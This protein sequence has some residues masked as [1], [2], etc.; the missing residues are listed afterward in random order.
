MKEKLPINAARDLMFAL[1][2]SAYKTNVEEIQADNC[3]DL[4]VNIMELH[5]EPGVRD[6]MIAQIKKIEGRNE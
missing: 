2:S 5:P 4:L 1:A 6:Y 3:F